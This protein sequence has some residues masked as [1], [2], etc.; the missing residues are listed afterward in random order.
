[1]QTILQL[2]TR[3]FVMITRITT[4]GF[5]TIKRGTR[6]KWTMKRYVLAQTGELLLKSTIA[7]DVS[8]NRKVVYLSRKTDNGRQN[9]PSDLEVWADKTT[10]IRYRDG[11]PTID[12]DFGVV[13]LPF[14][15]QNPVA[16]VS[17][18]SE[19]SPRIVAP[20]GWEISD[21]SEKWPQEQ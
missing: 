18:L 14:A 16:S 6:R 10:G 7:L 12:I 2:S 21:Y 3:N 4:K 1:M 20:P 11:Q 9:E 13:R 15:G 19:G 5:V 17:V 8:P